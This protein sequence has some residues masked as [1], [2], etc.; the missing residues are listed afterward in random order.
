MNGGKMWQHVNGHTGEHKAW[1]VLTKEELW[2]SSTHHQMMRPTDKAQILTLASTCT[3][4]DD[5]IESLIGPGEDV[6]A[7]W[8]PETD[9][10]CFQP[11]PEFDNDRCRAYFFELIQLYIGNRRDWFVEEGDDLD[12]VPFLKDRP[13]L[14]SMFDPEAG[15]WVQLDSKGNP[16]TADPL[17]EYE[18]DEQ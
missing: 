9:S 7:C 6:E 14:G 13:G 8:Y 4:R 15:K 5:A 17:D 3:R 16:V 12:D 10:L 11:H 2:V 1:D 18:D